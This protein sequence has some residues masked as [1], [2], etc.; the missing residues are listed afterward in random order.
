[1]NYLLSCKGPKGL[2]AN[3]LDSTWVIGK[4]CLNVDNGCMLGSQNFKDLHKTAYSH[5]LES[6]Y[7]IENIDLRTIRRLQE[8]PLDSTTFPKK[9]Y[10]QL[11][12]DGQF[13]LDFG[14]GFRQWI[15]PFFPLESI[16]VLGLSKF[17]E[18]GLLEQGKTRIADLLD[19]ASLKGLGQGHLVEICE[20]VGNYVGGRDSKRAETVD[21]AGWLLALFAKVEL[22]KLY[23]LLEKYQL[24]DLI[25]IT[26]AES[27]EVKRLN[28]EQREERYRELLKEVDKE[29]LN[30][31]RKSITYAFLIPWMSL[32]EGIAAR[33]EI[34]ERLERIADDGEKA[35][36]VL[37]LLDTCF[38][39]GFFFATH[40]T[41]FTA[42]LYA[43]NPAYA[44]FGHT[45]LKTAATYFYAPQIHYPLK[46]IV[47]LLKREHALSWITLPERF[48]EKVLFSAPQ[49]RLSK[50]FRGQMHVYAKASL[51]M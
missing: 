46:S 38:G 9:N 3:A 5:G 14:V 17:A 35:L 28:Q 40:L 21:F 39:N 20:K 8:N 42:D 7:S 29:L 2:L 48:I 41:P 50:N 24:Q 13:E 16:R 49:F 36:K 31:G 1:M 4:N 26:P 43:I 10:K 32:R 37:K 22:K 23:P 34:E 6:I 47:S 18:K 51:R 12:K 33:D 44:G 45:L 11:K 27:V 25:A 30:E 19:P 15:A